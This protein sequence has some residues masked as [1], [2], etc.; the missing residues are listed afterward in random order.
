[1]GLPRFGRFMRGGGGEWENYTQVQMDEWYEQQRM[2]R[3]RQWWWE[4]EARTKRE[5]DIARGHWEISDNLTPEE[6]EEWERL[7]FNNDLYNA[8]DK[9]GNGQT[10]K[11]SVF[12]DAENE[13]RFQVLDKKTN[14]VELQFMPSSTPGKLCC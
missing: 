2:E 6:T 13:A 10:W 3:D 1:M 8:V 5:E 11:D 7:K 4:E 12:K 14:H 9:T